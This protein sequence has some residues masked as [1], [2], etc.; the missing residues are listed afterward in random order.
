[1]PV[2]LMCLLLYSK[3]QTVGSC[4]RVTVAPATQ[5]LAPNPNNLLRTRALPA[6]A[7]SSSSGNRQ[8]QQTPPPRAPEGEKV[9]DSTTYTYDELVGPVNGDACG[10]YEVRNLLP[11][12]RVSA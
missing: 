8:Q 4:A 2:C 3:P 9:C 6:A 7:Q 11:L 1:M 5:P 12:G 10:S